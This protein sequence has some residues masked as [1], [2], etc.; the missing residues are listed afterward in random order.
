MMFKKQ[1]KELKKLFWAYNLW[2][3]MSFCISNLILT[4][5]QQ[6]SLIPLGEV[7][8]IDHTTPFGTVKNQSF[9][10]YYEI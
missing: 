3:N 9:Q 10:K 1:M 2:E 6:Q 5:Q 8:Y 7:G 4:E